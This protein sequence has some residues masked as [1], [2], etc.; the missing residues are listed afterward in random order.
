MAATCAFDSS[1]DSSFEICTDAPV[2]TVPTLR[3][4]PSAVPRTRKRPDTSEIGGVGRAPVIGA[5][6]LTGEAALDGDLLVPPIA[7]GALVSDALRYLVA[8]IA[9]GAEAVLAGDAAHSATARLA[10]RSWARAA[11]EGAV[12]GVGAAPHTV[13][14]QPHRDARMAGLLPIR[15]G[16]E[17]AVTAMES[18]EIVI[19]M[20]AAALRQLL[21]D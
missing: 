1:F 9:T 5:G 8:A 10:V 12:I 4:A 21:T 11:L 7:Y 14:G 15:C 2:S 16:G 20:A 18:D 19:L 3:G 6:A 13:I 17:G